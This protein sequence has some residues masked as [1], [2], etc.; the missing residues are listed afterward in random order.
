MRQD[1]A[2]LLD[3][4]PRLHR[5]YRRSARSLPWRATTDP[6]AVW[7]S[8]VMLQQTR[9]DTVLPYY[10]RWMAAFPTVD[11]LARAGDQDVLRVWEGLGYYARARNLHRAARVVTERLGGRIPDDP[12]GFLALPGVGPYTAA[13]VLSIA[14]G[15]PLAAVDGNVRRVLCRVLTLEEDPRTAAAARTLEAAARAL[16][17]RDVPG[18]H[19]QAMMELGAVVCTARNPACEG[20]PLR[21]ACRASARGCPHAY[22][23]RRPRRPVPHHHVAVGIVTRGSRVFIDRRPYG[24]LLGGLWEFPGGKVEPGEGVL[25]ALERELWEEFR[26]RVRVDAALDPVR[27]AYSHLRVT[28]HPFL[29]R[30]V[31]MDPSA[32]EGREWRWV[33]YGALPDHP[34]PRA[35]RKILEALGTA[36]GAA[37]DP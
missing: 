3:A 1:L 37:P 9:V 23:V 31:S 26:M 17:P 21:G 5:W 22:P 28:L 11:A 34:M 25:E 33:P 20:C 15:R 32:G 7:V 13:A 8:E 36:P 24:G 16:L 35:N 27:H 18:L 30:F 14:F 29:C 12:H 6:Y 19:N 2:P 4:I 10:R